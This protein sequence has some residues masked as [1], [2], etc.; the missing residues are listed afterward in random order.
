MPKVNSLQRIFSIILLSAL[1]LFSFTYWHSSAFFSPAGS[2]TVDPEV[3]EVEIPLNSSVAQVAAL[4]Q[5]KGIIKSA[6]L[7]RFYVRYRGYE[8][9]LQAGRYFLTA[10]MSVKEI[11]TRLQEGVVYL[12]GTRFTIPEGFTLK[13]I[14]A[15]LQQQGLAAGEEFLEACQ[16]FEPGDSFAFLREVPVE[17]GNLLE[18]YLFPDTYEIKEGAT[19][20]EIISVMLRRFNEIFDENY[21]RRAAELNFTIHEIVTLASLVEKEA[22]VAGERSV[23]AA[24]FHNRL[25]T[26]GMSLLQ[27]CATVQ[28]A[29]GETKP[30][31]TNADLKIDSPYNTYRYPG[32]PPGPIA[33]PGRLALEAALYPAEVDHLYFVYKEDGTGTHYFS[34]TLQEHNHYKAL[35]RGNR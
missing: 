22:R 1:I 12:E 9:Q 17:A 28:Y 32:L 24:V 21:R 25:G 8:Q 18:G 35:V 7:F 14:A 19:P 15:S 4:L 26:K 23:I 10:D 5:E 16:N 6:L 29:L 13:Q 3:I 34:T 33:S 11:L 30:H 27:S 2:S 20:E 31:L